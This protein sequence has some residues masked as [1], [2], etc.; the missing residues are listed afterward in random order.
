MKEN[1]AKQR[2]LSDTEIKVARNLDLSVGNKGVEITIGSPETGGIKSY[3]SN[4]LQPI[5]IETLNAKRKIAV[6]ISSVEQ[7]N[8]KLLHFLFRKTV[9]GEF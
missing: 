6:E 2:G 1:K 9:E 5:V 4:K 7:E 8:D 3:F